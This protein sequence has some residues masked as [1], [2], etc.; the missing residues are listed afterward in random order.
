MPKFVDKTRTGIP[1][2]G[3][4]LGKVVNESAWGESKA[5]ERYGGSTRTFPAPPERSLPQDCGD[6]WGTNTQGPRSVIDPSDWRR[7]GGQ[8]GESRPVGYVGSYRAPR[9]EPGDRTGP[10]L[11]DGAKGPH[12]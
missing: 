9:G 6:S 7:G 3:Q 10:P 2:A 11:R 4:G 8:G 5:T 12:K 1:G